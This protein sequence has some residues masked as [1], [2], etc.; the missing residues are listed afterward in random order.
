MSEELEML[1]YMK[2]IDGNLSREQNQRY[3]ELEKALDKI[4]KI[5][6]VIHNWGAGKYGFSGG[7]N[8]LHLKDIKNIKC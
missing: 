4:D 7:A 5:K 1:S 3:Y 6:K 8:A 2:R